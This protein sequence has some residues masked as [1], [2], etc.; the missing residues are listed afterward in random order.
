MK[1]STLRST[2]PSASTKKKRGRPRKYYTD[3]ERAEAAR[4][5]RKAWYYNEE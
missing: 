1:Q 5:Y 2:L 3:E 4:G